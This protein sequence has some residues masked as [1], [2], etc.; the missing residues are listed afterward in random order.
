[1]EWVCFDL[2]YI[3]PN[4]FLKYGTTLLFLEQSKSGQV[5]TIL[6]P[7]VGINILSQHFFHTYT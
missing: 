4:T 1:M 5:F 3:I 6:S 2:C 7:A